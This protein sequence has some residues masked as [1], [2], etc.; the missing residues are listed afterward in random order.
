[1]WTWKKLIPDC[2]TARNFVVV[3]SHASLAWT[4]PIL[5]AKQSRI[6]FVSRHLLVLAMTRGLSA[7]SSRKRWLKPCGHPRVSALK[8]VILAMS[9]LMMTNRSIRHSAYGLRLPSPERLIWKLWVHGNATCASKFFVTQLGSWRCIVTGTES[10]S[11]PM[12]L[13]K[14]ALSA[15]LW[16]PNTWN[17][18]DIQQRLRSWS[19]CKCQLGLPVGLKYSSLRHLEK[20]FAPKKP[21][22]MLKNLQRCTKMGLR[23]PWAGQELSPMPEHGKAQSVFTLKTWCSV[24]IVL[25]ITV[26]LLKWALF[27]SC[28]EV[29]FFEKKVATVAL[30]A[31]WVEQ[32]A[33]IIQAWKLTRDEVSAI[34]AYHWLVQ[35]GGGTFALMEM[36]NGI[37]DQDPLQVVV[38]AV[39][40]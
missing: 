11:A 26:G 39:L 31:C 35:F 16:S 19:C 3:L 20:C 25:W 9:K 1:M 6:A 17:V 29:V 34:E 7:Y 24:L 2:L 23:C 37:L 15:E 22:S 30:S 38:F 4:C 8:P 5:L 18:A 13:R 40:I 36:L 10:G 14:I 33:T 32:I 21:I 12:F 28:D 27:R